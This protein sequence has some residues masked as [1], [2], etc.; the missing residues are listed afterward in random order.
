M[1]S[2][3]RSGGAA[4]RGDWMG[5]L[6]TRGPTAG[7]AAAETI[8]VVDDDESIR[9]LVRIVLTTA[10]FEVVEAA[11]GSEALQV[12]A[13]HPVDAVLLDCMMPGAP[14]QEVLRDIRTRPDIA[15]I[16]VI[17]LTALAEPSH[18]LAGL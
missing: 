1:P 9:T 15:V 16:P 2:A 11:D 8:L 3:A 4:S 10:G 17:L 5:G 14:W 7:S 12:L 13:R 18:R 6:A